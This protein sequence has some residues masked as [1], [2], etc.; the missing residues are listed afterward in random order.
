MSFDIHQLDGLDYDSA[1]EVFEDY[2]DALLDSFIASPEGQAHLAASPDGW[3]FWASTFLELSHGYIGASIPEMTK[4][5]A[6]EV[7]TELF[8]RKISLLSP[9]DADGAIPEMV[10]FWRYLKREHALGQ[11]DEILD[12]LAELAPDFVRMMNDPSKFGMAKSILTM[13]QGAGFDMTDEA[14]IKAFINQFNTMSLGDALNLPPGM[15]GRP[16][17]AKKPAQT[18]SKRNRKA[19]R[20]SRKRNRKK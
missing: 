3:G 20:A 1:E 18:E 7:L 8:P 14:D 15:P 6:E 9:D 2:K 13:G 12:L 19:A 5:D 10:A 16:S 11:A 4:R 17:G